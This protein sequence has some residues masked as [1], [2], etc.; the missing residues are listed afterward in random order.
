MSVASFAT[1]LGALRVDW[2]DV[3]GEPENIPTAFENVPGPDLGSTDAPSV[4]AQFTV[5]LGEQ[6]QQEFGGATSMWRSAGVLSINVNVPLK[7]GDAETMRLVDLISDHY[8]GK[9][10]A[11]ASFQG[12]TVTSVGARQKW[13]QTNVAIPFW[14][15]RFV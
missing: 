9:D 8:R 1:F 14:A 3:I 2:L 11:G 7:S 13:W 5:I 12:P 15:N 4:W 6:S 10:I